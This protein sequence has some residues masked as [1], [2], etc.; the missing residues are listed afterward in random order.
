M[1]R[2]PEKHVPVL[3]GETG[4]QQGDPG[5]VEPPVVQHGEHH[6]VLAGGAGRSDA[7]VCLGLREAQGLRT[8]GEHGREGFTDV[9][10]SLVHFG[11]VGDPVLASRHVLSLQDPGV[12][13]QGLRPLAPVAPEDEVAARH[14]P[15]P[16]GLPMPLCLEGV[17]GQAHRAARLR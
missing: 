2:P 7:E 13:Q 5:Q 9:E 17:A 1:C 11:D 8:V 10:V 16:P 4:R 12:R 14:V 3:P 6:R 15:R